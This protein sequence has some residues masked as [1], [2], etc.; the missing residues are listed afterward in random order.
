MI[1]QPLPVPLPDPVSVVKRVRF[2]CSHPK[3]ARAVPMW[4]VAVWEFPEGAS[5][6]MVRGRGTI[7]PNRHGGMTW[8]V[9]C[10]VDGC[11]TDFRRRVD[12]LAG[13]DTSRDTFDISAS[14]SA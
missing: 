13:L 4:V 1:P 10:P 8:R 5:P 6:Q 2:V 11:R 3:L 12:A 9:D 14:N 7:A